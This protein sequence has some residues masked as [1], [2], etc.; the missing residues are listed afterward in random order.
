MSFQKGGCFITQ[1]KEGNT[2]NLSPL[3]NQPT[4]KN[5]IKFDL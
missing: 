1:Y 3:I 4:D 2:G 5:N